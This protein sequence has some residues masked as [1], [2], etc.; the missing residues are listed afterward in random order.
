MYTLS[1]PLSGYR[2][3]CILPKLSAC[4]IYRYIATVSFRVSLRLENLV[5]SYLLHSGP[6]IGAISPRKPQLRGC[7]YVVVAVESITVLP[8]TQFTF[9]T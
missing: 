7:C 9:Q 6:E 5:V 4:W 1:A 2:Y 8:E 3:M